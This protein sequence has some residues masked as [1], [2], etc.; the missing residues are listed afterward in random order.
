MSIFRF[1]RQNHVRLSEDWKLFTELFQT[2]G[3]FTYKESVQAVYFDD[4]AQRILGVEKS[5]PRDEYQRLLDKLMQEPVEGEQNLYYVRSGAE[6]RCLKLL[7]TRRGDEEIGFVEEFT[8]RILQQNAGEQDYDEV[9]GMLRLPA[10][11]RTVQQHLPDAGS[12]WL[13]ALHIEGLDKAADFSAAGSRNY[14]MASVAEVLGRFAGEQVLFTAKDFQNFYICFFGMD[15]QNVLLQLGQM[16]DAVAACIISDDFGQTM[17]TAHS[18]ELHAGLAVYPQESDTL[19]G[20]ITCAEFALFETKH[21]SQNPIVRFS[22]E[23]FG[24]KKDEYREEQLFSQII[25]Q[26]LL[27]YHFQPI[28][29]AHTGEII[30]YEALMR[31]EHFSPDKLLGIAEKTGRLY[32]IEKATLFNCLRFLSAH[33]N[34]F[35]NKSLF[36]NS[37]PTQLLTESDFGELRLMYE[38]LFGK[39]VIEITEQAE[40][41]DAMLKT[42]RQRCNEVGARLAIDDYGSGYANTAT[43]LKNKPEFVKID[44]EL[45]DGICKNSQKQQLVAG[46]IDYA[47]NNQITVLAEGVEE[48]ADLKTLIRMGVDLFQGFY[49]ARP[50]PYLLEE[51]SKDV[52]DV[53]VNTNLENSAF[54]KKIYNVHNDEEID[55]VQLALQNYT[56]IH[57]Y[58]HQLTIV[59]DAE[60]TVPMHIKIM[61]NHSCELTVRNVNMICQEKPTIS[62]GSYAH[63]TMIAEGVNTLHHM[64][65]RVPEGAYFCL[66]GSGS[67]KVDCCSK[68]GY[69][70]GGDC[71]SSYGCITIESEGRVELICNS[72]RG[73]GIGGGINPD[74]SEI[75]LNTGDVHILVGSPNTVGIGCMEGNALIYTKPECHLNIEVNGISSVGMGALTGEVHIDCVSDVQFNG[76][77]SK[78]VGIGVLNKGTGEVTVSDAKLEFFMRSNFAACIGAIG[79]EVEV[80]VKNCKVGVNAEGGEIT[81]I[82]DSKGS[83]DVTLDHTELKACILAAKPREAGSKDGRFIM[84]SSTIIADIN[85][86]QHNTTGD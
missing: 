37:I 10:F 63:L 68:F 55:L 64:G 27:T 65:V 22:P 24:K 4:N 30:G 49:T 34:A 48:E 36:I 67:L 45:L 71:D 3:A 59:G 82:G 51:I 47:H 2:I 58:R 13:A 31:S 41:S 74:D 8:R 19:R 54:Q 61:D 44:R 17:E 18:L 78:V 12:L 86:E 38:E 43:L 76:G 57:V 29:D 5:L 40:G 46:I 16:R 53:I 73:I 25:S 77:G 79:G 39:V 80:L 1:T 72:D 26:N 50:T 9:T 20:L 15:E 21:D 52:R 32:E 85:E 75:C 56:D 33:Q 7:V 28:V 11:S 6:K 69:C 60:K 35:S 14:C 70:I 81:G 84:K 62:I 66:N 83:G 23:D 42:L